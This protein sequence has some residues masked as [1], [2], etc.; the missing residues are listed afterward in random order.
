MDPRT[1]G[2]NGV[3]GVRLSLH[4]ASAELLSI[5]QDV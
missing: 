5:D 2:T 3:T 1:A 4:V